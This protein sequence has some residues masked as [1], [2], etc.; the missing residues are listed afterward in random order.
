MDGE[1]IA[2]EEVLRH[3]RPA[4]ARIDLDR[5]AANYGALQRLVPLPVM[6]VVKA[7]AYGHGAVP[8]ARRLLAAG[9]PLLAVA[10]V[11]EA[12]ALREEGFSVPIVVL[13]AFGPGQERMIRKHDLTPVVSTPRTL[14]AVLGP[15]REGRRPLSVHLK[16]DTGMSRLGFPAAGLR[17]A[18]GKLLETGGVELEGLM[19]HLASADE[20]AEATNRQL[21]A[22]DAARASLEGDGI[23]PPLVHAANSA[24]LSFLRPGHT[25]ARPGLLLYGLRPRPQSPDVDVRPVMS[26][27]ARIVLV[28]DV[29]AGTA[30]SYGGRFVTRRPSRL[31]TL[32]IGYADGVPRTAAMSTQGG[33]GVRG[34]AAPVAGAVCMD[35]TMVDLTDR[36]EVNEDDEAVYF[37]DAPTAWDVADRA[38][39]HAW[40]VLTSV[41]PR[42]PRVYLESGRLTG[43]ETRY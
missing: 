41:G 34:R 7:D 13:A 18:A 22:F 1:R 8:V 19:T 12:V 20:S 31:G 4:R 24:G 21:D 37:G 28:R 6:P 38:G 10:Y 9:A 36:P 15:A 17:Q 29:P 23:R 39:T 33:F 5:L 2:L 43:V 40:Q 30:V 14:E 26:V 35:Y 3:L 42:V 32:P 27:S 16:V 25:L 11:E